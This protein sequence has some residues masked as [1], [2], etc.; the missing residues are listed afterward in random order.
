MRAV[1][2]FALLTA[3]ATGLIYEGFGY[4][5]GRTLI[6]AMLGLAFIAWSQRT[7]ET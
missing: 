1:L 6:G 2:G 4:A 5:I 3:L 7:I